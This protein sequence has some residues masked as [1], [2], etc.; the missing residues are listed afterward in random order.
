MCRPLLLAI[1]AVGSAVFSPAS[2]A[3][4]ASPAQRLFAQA[5]GKQSGC[6]IFY[7]LQPVDANVL[8]LLGT[9]AVPSNPNLLTSPEYMQQRDW[10]FPSKVTPWSERPK[11]EEIARRREELAGTSAGSESAKPKNAAIPAWT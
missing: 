8:K 4:T 1:T 2:P 10:D 9:P 7:A 5:S 6:E 11:P 3:Q